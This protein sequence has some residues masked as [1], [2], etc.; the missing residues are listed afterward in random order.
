[1]E[2]QFLKHETV[3]NCDKEAP[4]NIIKVRNF[5]IPAQA[6]IHLNASNNFTMDCGIRH[7]EGVYFVNLM[8]L[9][10]ANRTALN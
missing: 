8:T 10:G 5:V 9:A 4:A 3:Y 1:M 6:G 7:N 2:G